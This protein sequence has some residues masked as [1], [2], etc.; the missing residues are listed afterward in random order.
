MKTRE[1]LIDHVRADDRRRSRISIAHAKLRRMIAY[2]D[3]AGCRRAGATA[4]WPRKIAAMLVG[5]TEGLPV[6]LTR[7]STTG[8][9]TAADRAVDRIRS[10]AGLIGDAPTR[11][12][13]RVGV[14]CPRGARPPRE[15]MVRFIQDHREQY[16]VEPLCVVL[17][18][19]PST[20]TAMRRA[21]STPTRRAPRTQRD[22]A[23][24]EI[25]R[26]HDE[27]HQVYGSRKSGSS[28]VGNGAV[29][30]GA[31][32]RRV[33]R[34]RGLEGAV[35]GRAWVTTAYAGNGDRLEDLVDRQFVAT[36]PNQLWVSDFTYV[37]SSQARIAELAPCG[38][39]N[40]G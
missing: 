34:A 35:R 6:E 20:F 30:R 4:V 40:G 33:M 5:Y 13:V 15:V 23:V 25:Q 8:L 14:F 39:L 11:S 2:A 26:V 32:F 9:L 24:P 38:R 7:L 12:S 37:V 19:A 27:H 10:A 18:I 36:R 22:I 31:I 28:C 17:P 3:T 21:R 29:W 16:R 1:F